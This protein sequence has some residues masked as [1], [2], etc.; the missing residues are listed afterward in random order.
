MTPSTVFFA[1][2]IT[3]AA[4]TATNL[5]KALQAVLPNI[6]GA[7]KELYIQADKGV[8]GTLLIGD[9]SIST[10]RYG[11]EQVIASSAPIAPQAFG[12]GSQTNSVLLGNFY[13]Y[14]TAEMKVNV[15]GFAV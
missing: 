13:L 14:S 15:L 2:Q 11:M 7:V 10:S 5:L 4:N 6:I 12:T 8:N 3:L 1:I 9:A